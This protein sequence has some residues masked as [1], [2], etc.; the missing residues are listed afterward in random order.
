MPSFKKKSLNTSKLDN[1]NQFINYLFKGYSGHKP[2]ASVIVIKDGEIKFEKSY[3]YADIKNN[4]LATSKT[5]YRVAS[6]TKQ[7]TAMAII[8]LVNQG[9]LSYETKLTDVFP[10]FPDYGKD[11]SIRHLLTHPSGLVKYTR[12]IRKGQ[13]EQ[14]LDRDVL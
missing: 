14:M 8:I 4:I 2:S 1:D 12:F 11:I 3:G 13:T 5:N 7:F 10:D 9:K 6:V